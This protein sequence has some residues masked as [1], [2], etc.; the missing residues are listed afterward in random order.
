ML[1]RPGIARSQVPVLLPAEHGG[2]YGAGGVIHGQQ[3]GKRG[4]SFPQ[5]AVVAAVD[6]HQHSLLWHPLPANPALLGPTAERAADTGLDQDATHGG[7]A[8]I[9]A[10]PL[11]K[12]LGQ[13]RVVGSRVLGAGQSHHCGSLGIQDGVVRLASPVSMRQGCCSVPA[14]GT[15]ELSGVANATSLI[16]GHF[17]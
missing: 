5:P 12:Q 16:D 9:Y 4:P 6:L 11:A 8:Q 1:L 3:Q 13:V 17:R 14:V 15:K 10:L 7:A 2:G